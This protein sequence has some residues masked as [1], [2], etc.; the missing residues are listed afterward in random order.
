MAK[1][2][3]AAGKKHIGRRVLL[4]VLCVLLVAVLVAAYIFKDEISLLYFAFTTSEE[5]VAA[6][7]EEN[8]KKNQEL[9]DGVS[10]VTMR[11]L[12][13]EERR[14]LAE[15]ILSYDD[16]LK[17]IMG[18]DFVLGT[19]LP[20]ETLVPDVTDSP[21]TTEASE[22]PKVTEPAETTPA[23]EETTVTTTTAKKDNVITDP[24]EI[25]KCR[26]RINEI[27][28]EIY[29]LRATYLNEI[30]KLIDA[31][32]EEYLALPKAKHNLNGKLELIEKSIIP[33]GYA[34]EDECDIKMN[35]LLDELRE[36]LKSLGDDTDI[37]KQIKDTYAEQKKL[38]KTELINKYMPTK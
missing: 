3:E 24:A 33:K 20:D 12:T 26:N 35:I 16:A 4:T 29:L 36:I 11:D 25:E 5:D 22:V 17:L 2:L 7:Q 10:D 30:D 37:I 1:K 38:K 21:V 31:M 34:L 27:I 15:G 19:D 13:E 8:D 32:R 6:K 18:E 23:T 14:L 28:A 9:L